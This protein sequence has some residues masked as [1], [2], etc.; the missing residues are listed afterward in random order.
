MGVRADPF[1][2]SVAL[3]IEDR[4]WYRSEARNRFA[5][6]DATSRPAWQAFESRPTTMVGKQ[7]FE[8]LRLMLHSFQVGNGK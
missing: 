1:L 2:S 3:G 7:I 8:R 4:D 5:K 6:A